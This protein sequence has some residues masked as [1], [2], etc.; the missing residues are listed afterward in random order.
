M[1]KAI[2]KKSSIITKLILGIGIGIASLNFLQT[3]VVS[4]SA[5]LEITRN[6]IDNYANLK[7]ASSVVM[8]KELE[9][10]LKELDYYILADVMQNG[11]LEEMADWLV[12]HEVMRNKDFDYIMLAG[13]DGYSYNDIGSRTQI[14]DRPYFKAIM[15]QG[16]DSYIDDP[17]ISKTTGQPVIHITRA[18]KQNGRTVAMIAGVMNLSII[19]TSIDNVKIGKDGYGWLMASDGTVIA[20]PVKEYILQK[21]FINGLP[22]GFEAMSEA[23]KEIADR[24][25]GE[26]WVKDA[27]GRNVL[28][29]Y[30]P[31]NG[32]PWGMALS[33]PQNQIYDIISSIRTRMII[34][35]TF[36]VLISIIFAFIVLKKTIRPLQIVEDAITDIASG[37]ADLTRRI[38]INSNN[39]IG[40]VVKGFNAFASKLQSIISDV[41]NSK[42][43]LTTAG[44]NMEACSEDTASSI[45]EIL[46]NI[47]SVH[48]QITNQ[49]ASVEET[50]GAVNQIASNI[51]SLENM[52]ENQ[53]AGVAQA[54]AAVEEMIGNIRSVNSSV[55]KMADAFGALQGRAQSGAAK[56]KELGDKII[57]IESQSQM[58]QEANKAIASIASQT[59]LLAMNAAI[60]AAHAGE[61][62]KG[63]SVV[64]EEIRKLSETSATQSKTIGDQLKRIK[65]SIGNVVSTAQEG[66][67]MFT[68]VADGIQDTDELVR[69]IKAALTEQNEGSKQISETLH[70]MNDSTIEVRNASKEMSEGNRAIL[71]EVR[72]LQDATLA[73]KDSM[74]EMSDGARKINETGVALS[75]I[76]RTV[77]NSISD[78]GERIDLFLV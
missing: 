8:Q 48:S 70:S 47:E 15:L 23:A 5:R 58:L 36:V 19:T 54:S 75:E 3:V 37:S 16:K 7:E 59:N 45:T 49:S 18:V 11:T 35:G 2:N 38:N 4:R 67:T 41:K 22:A 73:M 29:T 25:I 63:F 31:V 33:I 17:V 20:H 26:R 42:D 6:D 44:D 34:F 77:R 68:S 76:S 13:S 52:I 53:S 28:V 71:E 57:Q 50:A 78:I 40:A 27:N 10:Y 12:E 61:A 9:G 39:E 62:G 66:V 55:D 32:T 24:K 65:N 74:N 21:N 64:A 69:Q 1:A 72:A 56:Q 46:A 43:E 60:E 30:T 14:S 51:S